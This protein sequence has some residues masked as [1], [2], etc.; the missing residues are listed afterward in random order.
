MDKTIKGTSARR[1]PIKTIAFIALFAAITAVT[2]PISVPLPFGE[3]PLSLAM[4]PILLTGSVLPFWQ[5]IAAI[6][7]YLLLGGV[8]VPVF[9]GYKS[10]FSVLF[11]PTGGYLLGYL[12]AVAVASLFKGK[13]I[14][15]FAGMLLAL[16]PC[17]L[18]G[19]VWL[20][21]V[22]GMGLS[23]AVAI[24]VLPF[25]LPDALKA[26]LAALLAVRLQPL[27]RKK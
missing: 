17:Y 11:G 13:F 26:L 15:V 6:G 3:V 27:L 2:A 9:A 8:G 23:K 1:L 5:A 21:L 14:K 20:S 16:V 18:L 10:G 7:V 25:I 12:P 22:T 4:L 19:S 24:G